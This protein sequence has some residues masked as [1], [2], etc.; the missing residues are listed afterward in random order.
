VED[1][2]QFV[3]WAFGNLHWQWQT[4]LSVAVGVWV[5][6]VKLVDVYLTNVKGGQLQCVEFALE[7]HGFEERLEL[8]GRESPALVT[9]GGVG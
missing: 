4:E 7:R 2:T 9:G 3:L 6:R 5:W 1:E 8:P